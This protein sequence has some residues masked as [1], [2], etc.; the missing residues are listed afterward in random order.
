MLSST[1]NE[2]QMPSVTS[3]TRYDSLA[4]MYSTYF[5]RI[6]NYVYYRV[7][8]SYDAED[9][10]S[11]IFIKLFS[12]LEYYQENKAPLS[13]WIFSIARNTVT[14]YYRSRSRQTSIALDDISE[15]AN[16]CDGPDFLVVAAETHLALR[17]ALQF[18]SERERK[19]IK[20]KFCC[21]YSNKSI[22][23]SLGFS[24]SNVGVILYRAILRLRRILDN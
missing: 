9:I 19:I 3:Q 22:A 7:G 15:L 2:T 10:T 24:E 6:Y 12:K 16:C 21:E 14:D 5:L 17:T 8:N 4:D 20:L 1:P 13:A 18:L 11:Q 23:K